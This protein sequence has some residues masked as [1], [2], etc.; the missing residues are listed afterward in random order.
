[1]VDSEFYV[2]ET[3]CKERRDGCKELRESDSDNRDGWIKNIDQK[4]TYLIWFAL[5][6]AC[7]VIIALIIIKF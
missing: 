3:H 7:A 1:M 6:Q 5:A 2:T 4:L